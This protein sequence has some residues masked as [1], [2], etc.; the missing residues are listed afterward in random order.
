MAYQHCIGR[1]QQAAGR[2]LTDKEVQRIFERIHRA[3][4]DIKAG[5]ATT[6][7]PTGLGQPVVI[8]LF[9]QSTRPIGFIDD[10]G[11]RVADQIPR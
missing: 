3:A 5:R 1:L 6:A 2:E 9:Q 11:R 8:D 7:K 4:L 10:K